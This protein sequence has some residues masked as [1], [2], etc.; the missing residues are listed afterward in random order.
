VLGSYE[1]SPELAVSLQWLH[2]PVDGSGI[3]APSASV[4]FGDKVSLLASAYWPYG[5]T[6]QGTTVRSEYGTAS[7]SG[8]L[9]VRIYE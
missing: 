7:R 2:G 4:T 5:R 6:P 9:Q 8:L 1:V 3:L